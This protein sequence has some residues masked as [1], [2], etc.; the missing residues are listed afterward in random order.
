MQR[1]YHLK[2]QDVIRVKKEQFENYKKAYENQRKRMANAFPNNE[3]EDKQENEST[4]LQIAI[5][6]T[7][8]EADSLLELLFRRGIGSDSDSLKSD[9]SSADTDDRVVAIDTIDGESSSS[10]N[11]APVGTKRPK[12]ENM[13]IEELRTLN[14]Q[15]H[16]LVYQLVT[17]LDASAREGDAL[18]A[19]VKYLE[20]ERLK[21]VDIITQHSAAEPATRNN[22]LRVITDSSGGTSPYVFSPCS[23]LSPDAIEN[24][25]LPTLTPLELPTFDFSSLSKHTNSKV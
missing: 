9:I 23:E 15:L 2:Q 19:R 21:H 5:Y 16:T 25:T 24:M 22:N 18:R 14:Q 12:D 10:N 1:D 6:K 3:F 7:M 13:V 11:N 8:E 17:Q 4:S 20:S